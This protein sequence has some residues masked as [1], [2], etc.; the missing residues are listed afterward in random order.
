[1]DKA[2]LFNQAQ[3]YLQKGQHDKALK[4]LE[5]IV[6]IDPDDVKIHI[7][8]G[9]IHNRR[10]NREDALESYFKAAD[11][12]VQGGFSQKAIAVY[13]QALN[14]DPGSSE[15][16]LKL[17]D[18]YMKASLLPDSIK[19]YEL[20]AQN[21][22]SDGLLD[23][24]LDIY[25][26]LY[27]LDSQRKHF[28]LKQGEL[29]F[30]KGETRQAVQLL[31]P[32]EKAYREEG[33]TDYLASLYELTLSYDPA[34]PRALA[35]L[36]ALLSKKGDFGRVIELLQQPIQNGVVQ[37][38]ALHVRLCHALEQSGSR[39]SALKQYLA[40]YDRCQANEPDPD[41][42]RPILKEIIRLDPE[43][44]QA[45]LDLEKLTAVTQAVEQTV[46]VPESALMAIPPYDADGLWR[47]TAPAG[48]D[49]LL[50]QVE[51]L[52][53]YKIVDLASDVV[54]A[55]LKRHPGDPTLTQR[56]ALLAPPIDEMEEIEVLEPEEADVLGGSVRE[57]RLG[58]DGR[59]KPEADVTPARMT[60]GRAVETPP[61]LETPPVAVDEVI[62]LSDEVLQEPVADE[63]SA[64]FR[65][66][67]ASAPAESPSWEP[68][69][70]DD[71]LPDSQAEPQLDLSPLSEVEEAGIL[72]DRLISIDAPE[73]ELEAPEAPPT[74]RHEDDTYQRATELIRIG[75]HAEALDL[76]PSQGSDPDAD[77]YL[78]LRITCMKATGETHALLDCLCGAAER[79]RLD[80]EMQAHVRYEV[81]VLYESMGQPETAS[82]WYRS[83]MEFMPR[84]RD[85]ENRVRS[86]SPP[87]RLESPAE[88]DVPPAPARTEP[89]TRPRYNIAYI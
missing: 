15:I 20:V 13:K 73:P 89:T 22:E 32:L 81:G 41:T 67:P 8:I 12:F 2:A 3:K 87:P 36:S 82:E 86:L 19:H 70:T 29:L 52:T 80:L 14:L 25:T 62:E 61:L 42:L 30:K 72:T 48:P 64:V 49:Q 54:R 44:Q 50:A 79:S 18:L 53:K 28:L 16:H 88:V 10:G 57:D 27:S 65:S 39:P 83:V 74:S 46:P 38:T 34:N 40:L 17:A 76:L 59:E 26:Q 68:P 23:D 21:C 75:R 11:L 47:T 56:A 51:I 55:G 66:M 37:D 33:N 58:Q 78:L 60:G 77:P 63:L 1:M 31:E 84:Y 24:A 6:E 5:K 7:Q 35:E 85:V 43:N 45:R 4:E 9:E 71:A 69:S